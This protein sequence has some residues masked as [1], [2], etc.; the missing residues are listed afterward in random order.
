[1]EIKD[2]IDPNKLP[3]HIAVIMD[4][5][6]RWAEKNNKNRIFGHKNGVASVRS[7]SET[8]AELGV[9]YLTLYAF[10]EENWN[11]PKLEVAA[12][13]QLLVRTIKNE[14]TT[15]QKN[16][17]KLNTIG[18]L[19]L[20]PKNC[21]EEL[22]ISEEQTKNNDRMT[23]TLALSYSSR[24]EIT[25]A[26]LKIAEGVKNNKISLSDI[27]S[28]LVSKNLYTHNLPDPD[29]VI[30]T[31]GEYRISNFL[32]WQSAYSEYYFTEKYWPEFR[33]ND[34]YEAIISYQGRERRFGKIGQ[35][36]RTK[37]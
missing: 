10:S 11:R 36:V 22:L 33:E 31:S 9:K 35:Q 20:L 16:K 6:G 24:Q 34:L 26:V 27:D 8:C 15:L 3:E 2:N 23:L 37:A 1:M 7:I 17:I 28:E 25:N 30:R 4:G 32:L 5:N 19:G 12:L 21:R 18:N 14:T 29:L 13:M